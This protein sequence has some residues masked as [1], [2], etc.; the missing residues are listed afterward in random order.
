MAKARKQREPEGE[1]TKAEY[2]GALYALQVE[3]V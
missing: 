2:A 1:L 3:L